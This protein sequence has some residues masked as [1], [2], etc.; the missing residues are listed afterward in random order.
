[1]ASYV[2]AYAEL[3]SMLRRDRRFSVYPVGYGG[4]RVGSLVRRQ[5]S[6]DLAE[7][8]EFLNVLTILATNGDIVFLPGLRV[9]R[10]CNQDYAIS[11]SE[12]QLYGPATDM[13]KERLVAVEASDHPTNQSDRSRS[14]RGCRLR[15]GYD[16]GDHG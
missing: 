4:L 15:D 12:I 6:A 1:M 8:D 2:E 11:A 16:H 7:Q 14:L 9:Q 5:T 13:E 10:F 3:F